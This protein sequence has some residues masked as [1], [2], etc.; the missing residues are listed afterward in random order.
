LFFCYVTNI[1]DQREKD[2]FIRDYYKS[3]VVRGETPYKDDMAEGVSTAYYESGELKVEYN[4]KKGKLEGSV[5]YYYES[6]AVEYEGF[7]SND[8]SDG[9][10]RRYYEN[11]NISEEIYYKD[12]SAESGFCV[13]SDGV[14]TGF[15]AKQIAALNS[16]ERISSCK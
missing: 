1:F 4:S 7:Y 13:T 11:G 15:T 3:G 12:G 6:G 2:G 9:L 14:R 10:H 16:G 5:K 8:E